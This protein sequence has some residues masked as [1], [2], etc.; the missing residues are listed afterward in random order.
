MVDSTFAYAAQDSKIECHAR[1]V[2]TAGAQVPI[3]R[4]CHSPLFVP[5]A[6]STLPFVDPPSGSAVLLHSAHGRA[7]LISAQAAHVSPGQAV[8]GSDGS[9]HD[10]V[11]SPSPSSVI[12]V[13]DRG[14]VAPS[15]SSVPCIAVPSRF[16]RVV[17]DTAAVR[18]SDLPDPANTTPSAP[19]LY[20]ED[21]E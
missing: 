7:A 20:D 19:E 17:V 21:S 18:D 5:A 3:V 8:D 1:I 6:P 13:A 15:A 12:A 10:R 14:T 16:E 2:S 11:C 9:I 4:Q